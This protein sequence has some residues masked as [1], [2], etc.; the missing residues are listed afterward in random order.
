MINSKTNDNVKLW[1][2]RKYI[3]N[4]CSFLKMEKKYYESQKNNR[5]IHNIIDSFLNSLKGDYRQ[6]FTKNFVDYELDS[7]WY[8]DYWS[9]GTYY[10]KL[11]YVTN[12]FLRFINDK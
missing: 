9:K 11:N 3:E 2:K 7:E 8:L 6:I 12:L 5:A 4:Y 10:K 1:D